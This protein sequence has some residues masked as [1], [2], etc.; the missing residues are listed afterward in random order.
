MPIEIRELTIKVNI[1][2]TGGN[3]RDKTVHK[4][5]EVHKDKLKEMLEESAEEIMNAIDK[6]SER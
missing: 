4:P 5:S 6:K 1:G 3:K 2:D